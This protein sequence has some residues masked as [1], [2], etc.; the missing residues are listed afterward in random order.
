MV[1]QF[2]VGISFTN[3]TLGGT[4]SIALSSAMKLVT[5]D[6]TSVTLQ[7]IQVIQKIQVMQVAP[8]YTTS[9]QSQDFYANGSCLK[10]Q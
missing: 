2:D 10:L 1:H 5:S 6:A 3:L 9:H 4:G 8:P 7:V